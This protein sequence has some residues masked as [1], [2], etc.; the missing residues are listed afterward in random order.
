MPGPV[1]GGNSGSTPGAVRVI[2]PFTIYG[3]QQQTVAITGDAGDFTLL[4]DSIESDAINFDDD[5]P[6]ATTALEAIPA[7]DGHITVVR[8]GS[9]LNIILDD[10][11]T[12]PLLFVLGTNNLTDGVGAG[13]VDVFIRPASPRVVELYTPN[14]GDEIFDITR[15]LVEEF[16]GDASLFFGDGVDWEVPDS[17][18]LNL[19]EGG[20]NRTNFS[21]NSD[22]AGAGY[23][24]SVAL[25][26]IGELANAGALPNR[27]LVSAPIRAHLYQLGGSGNVTGI[28]KIYL[29][30]ATPAAP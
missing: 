24:N 19:H 11:I 26:D 21:G 30:V 23:G 13:A 18:G 6:T 22:S 4:Y 10:S 8:S 5:G 7:L 29:K 25:V 17:I 2:G 1:S 9:N 16:D 20:N 15:E 14:V 3:V 27:C 28:V 12:V